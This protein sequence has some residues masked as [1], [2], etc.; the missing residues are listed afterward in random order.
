MKCRCG[1]ETRVTPRERTILEEIGW[2]R[3]GRW[4][5]CPHC[6]QEPKTA[7]YV[8]QG[9]A[10]YSPLWGSPVVPLAEW[11]RVRMEPFQDGR[12]CL[13]LMKVL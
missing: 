1:A 9:A 8:D 11:W 6:I 13:V 2:V 5:F 3:G 12:K 7:E 4:Q 10:T